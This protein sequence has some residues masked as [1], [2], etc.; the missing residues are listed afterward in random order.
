MFTRPKLTV[1]EVIRQQDNTGEHCDVSIDDL[2]N[3]KVAINDRKNHF[4]W[5][6]FPCIS[7]NKSYLSYEGDKDRSFYAELYK[8]RVNKYLQLFQK[9]KKELDTLTANSV[10]GIY[11]I[12][13]SKAVQFLDFFSEDFLQTNKAF[14]V[15]F[16]S[17]I[18]NVPMAD[19]CYYENVNAVRLKLDMQRLTQQHATKLQPLQQLGSAVPPPQQAQANMSQVPAQLNIANIANREQDMQN[20]NVQQRDG[21]FYRQK[22][23]K[24]N[25][26]LPAKQS[27]HRSQLQKFQK[28]KVFA[29]PN[30]TQSFSQ[31]APISLIKQLYNNA[32]SPVTVQPPQV[33]SVVPPPADTPAVVPPNVESIPPPVTPVVQP[34]LTKSDDKKLPTID[35]NTAQPKEDVSKNVSTPPVAKVE[36][37]DNLMLSQQIANIFLK[38]ISYIF[39]VG[40]IIDIIDAITSKPHKA[41][42]SNNIVPLST[43][44]T[45]NKTAK[46]ATKTLISQPVLGCRELQICQPVITF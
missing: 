13:L 38:I 44:Q 20:F 5:I 33:A 15:D 43:K 31:A 42:K 7:K 12:R 6:I 37:K 30:K 2:I 29:V 16:M 3:G 40:I 26:F 25:V 22:S 18:E 17:T 46:S 14:F 19:D 4:D 35:T 41:I 11:Q 27:S 8:Q 39:I 23:G 36:T 21:N 10:T 1:D 24:N 32:P 34:T 28:D 9:Y 45:P